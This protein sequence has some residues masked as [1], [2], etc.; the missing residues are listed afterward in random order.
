[1]ASKESDDNVYCERYS[2]KELIEERH[3]EKKKMEC[4]HDRHSIAYLMDMVREV[5]LM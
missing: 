2:D 1:M 5:F 4:K 3:L